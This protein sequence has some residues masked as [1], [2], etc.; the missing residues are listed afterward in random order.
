M[1]P[2]PNPPPPPPKKY[3]WVILFSDIANEHAPIKRQ[4]CKGVPLPWMNSYKSEAM[5]DRDRLHRKFL[6]SNHDGHWNAYK[7]KRNVVNRLVKTAKSKYYCDLIEDAG[8]DSKRIWKAVNEAS[9]RK[10]NSQPVQCIVADGVHHLTPKSIATTMNKF[11]SCIGKVLADKIASHF[12]YFNRRVGTHFE[13][14]EVDESTVLKQLHA[15][16]PNKAI[17]LDNISARLLKC[18]AHT[19]APSITKLLNVSIRTGTVPDLW[20]CS[21]ITALFKA[22]DRTN[23]SN[24]RPISI[25]PTLCKLL[26]RTIH[27]QLYDYLNAND[28]LTNKQFGFRR[29]SSTVSA[30][31][32]FADEMLLNMEQGNFYGAVFIDLTKA[33]DTVCHNTLLSKLSAIGV[34]DHALL[35]FQS[36]LG[37][38]KQRVSCGVELSEELPVI[39]GVPQG[40]IL[41]PLLFIVYIN[42][43][44]N[45]LKFSYASLYA[46][47][48]VIYCYGTDTQ[49]IKEKL[50]EDLLAIANWLNANKLTL[51]LDKTKCMLIGSTRKIANLSLTVSILNHEIDSVNSF[52]YLGIMISSDFT[53]SDHI[54]Y[55]AKKINQRLGLL[56]RIKHL[57]PFK[58]RLLFFNSLVLPLFDYADVVWGD[59]NNATLMG[60][61]QILQNKAAKIILNRPFY[62]SSKEALNA[63]KW[64]PLS[65]RRHYRR[66]T[67]IYKC[68]K[69][70]ISH[71]L[72]LE[73]QRDHHNYNTRNNDHFRLPIIKRNWG[74]QRLN[75]HALSEYNVLPK[76]IRASSSIQAFKH[77]ILDYFRV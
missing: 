13:L 75:Y 14:K 63:L 56:R 76:E 19:I 7:K 27:T 30:L 11:F 53:W 33:F 64:L 52:K 18:S 32:A 77:K 37:N 21:K 22:G 2:P 48:T 69:G 47:D 49:D 29:G 46:D 58:S 65:T 54:D 40:S 5:K 36:Y 16:K 38:R 15:L 70:L 45:S 25:L 62:S 31:S 12:Q 51:N 23:A 24:Y 42:D 8:G 1:K 3:M 66:C 61:L 20:K 35:W 57:L 74:K 71:H 9:A 28:L 10:S 39:Y 73:L 17:G 50:N 55:I 44:P 26:E 60:N 68:H 4:R 41:G 67:Y 59:K 6:K 72:N 43:L 34:T